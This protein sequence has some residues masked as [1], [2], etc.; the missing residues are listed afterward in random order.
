MTTDLEQFQGFP[1]IPRL[2]RDIIIT[3]KIDGT[4]AQIVVLDDGSVKAASR[5]RWVTKE[6]DNYGFASWVDQNKDELRSLG[7]G[8]HYGEW[9]GAGIQR[10]YGLS[11]KRFALFNTSKW[12]QPDVGQPLCCHAVPVLYC[13]PFSVTAVN[14][15][16]DRL[17]KAGSFAVPG[18]MN[19]EGII[20]YH[21]AGGHY[22][23]VLV[24]NDEGHKNG[25]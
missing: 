18:Y 19:P 7:V 21:T 4:N 24:E 1:K 17:K 22:Y 16:L 6:S 13:G 25:S 23:K 5:N 12:G 10:K 11:E 8:R 20:V 9:Y 3:E 2:N 14:D 15:Q